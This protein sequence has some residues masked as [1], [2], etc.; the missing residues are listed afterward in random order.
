MYSLKILLR[1]REQFRRWFIKLSNSLT[2]IEMLRAGLLFQTSCWSRKTRHCTTSSTRA[3]S[4]STTWTTKRKCRSST[5]D[6]F[7]S[8]PFCL[9]LFLTHSRKSAYKRT[10]CSKVVDSSLSRRD[11]FVGLI[12]KPSV[13]LL[14]YC[15]SRAHDVNCKASVWCPSVWQCL[16]VP[17]GIYPNWLARTASTRP[18]YVLA[19][20]SDSRY[21]CW[22]TD[23]IAYDFGK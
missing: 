4:P 10:G 2:T 22:W 15:A 7:Y 12:A 16:S 13:L 14:V 8:F 19:V 20:L 18:A 23:I 9:N 1:T 6:I 5:C 11:F 17:S 3:V 21:T